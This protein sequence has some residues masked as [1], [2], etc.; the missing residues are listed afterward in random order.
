MSDSTDP[1]AAVHRAVG[2][3]Q[4]PSGVAARTVTLRREYP[5]PVGEVWAA[6][7]DAERLSRWFLP[8]TGDLRPGGSYRLE[9]NA[10]GRILECEPPRL[11]RVSWIFGEPADEAEVGEVAVRLTPGG[12][13]RT[14]L[15]LE[16][17]A[18]VD[19]ERWTTYGPGAVGVGWDLGLL[20]LG[21]HLRGE[22][23]TD[24]EAWGVSPEARDLMTRSSRAWGEAHR[25]S[26]ATA[27]EAD[28][29]MRN[30][31]AFYVPGS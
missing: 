10:G 26:G 1:F 18:T 29:A 2:T 30:T 11:L 14:A 5:A 28:T 24:P 4:L 27:D 8:V 13:D 3:R 17:L 6:C 21:R 22:T 20:G 16:H 7:T 12:E 31:T 23:I 9:G 15:E 19:A 25:A